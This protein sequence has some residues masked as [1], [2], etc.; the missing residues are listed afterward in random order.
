M[1]PHAA[2]AGKPTKG[3]T[4]VA[5]RLHN[6]FAGNERRQ[7]RSFGP[8]FRDEN[9]QDKWKL[10]VSTV[11]EPATLALWQQHLSEVDPEN[12]TG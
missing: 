11:D 7:V 2:D 9:K 12:R 10:R 1:K 8:P 6:L 4:A 3:G 5:E